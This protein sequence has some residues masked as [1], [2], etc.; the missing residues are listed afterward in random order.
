MEKAKKFLV[1][2]YTTLD[3]EKGGDIA[4]NLSRLYAYL[5]ERVN[6]IEAT[7][8]IKTIEECKGILQNIREGWV[9]LA[10]QKKS[11]V[12]VKGASSPP[13]ATRKNLSVSI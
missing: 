3:E 4:Q 8:D 10:H 9:G 7:K 6:F 12:G 11:E 2:L 1:H 5:I 13:G